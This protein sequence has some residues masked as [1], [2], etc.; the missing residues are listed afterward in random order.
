MPGL[1]NWLLHCSSSVASGLVDAHLLITVKGYP[2]LCTACR[3]CLGALP[4]TLHMRLLTH[5]RFTHT[6]QDILEGQTLE[7]RSRTR[8][9]AAERTAVSAS[10]PSDIQLQHLFCIKG[11]L[12]IAGLKAA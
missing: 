5:S 3:G 9:R 8:R 7:S 6:G 4:S 1:W 11:A 2:A 10:R 12:S